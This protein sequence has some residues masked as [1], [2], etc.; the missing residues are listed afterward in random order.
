MARFIPA[1]R[2]RGTTGFEIVP[3]ALMV[4]MGEPMLGAATL[5]AVLATYA[6]QYWL[7]VRAVQ[8]QQRA[9]LNFAQSTTTLGADPLPVIAALNDSDSEIGA[10]PVRQPALSGTH[11]RDPAQLPR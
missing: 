4:V 9:I 6:L 11:G 1:Q 3:P 2:P 7:A 5:G 8:Q 10:E